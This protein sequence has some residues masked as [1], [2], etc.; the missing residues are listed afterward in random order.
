MAF[1]FSISQNVLVPIKATYLDDQGKPQP[2]N[3]GLLCERRDAEGLAKLTAE[4]SRK[5]ADVMTEVARGFVDLQDDDGQPMAFT[6]ENLQRV[7]GVAGMA[8]TAFAAYVDSIGVK[9]AE[10]N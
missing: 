7:L 4:P 3:F 6:P 9:A 10:K 5:L 1:K 2:M 8:M